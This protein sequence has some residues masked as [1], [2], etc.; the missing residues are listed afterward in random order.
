MKRIFY[1]VDFGKF[2]EATSRADLQHALRKYVN[3]D[4]AAEA[5]AN[6]VWS[7]SEPFSA[8][9]FDKRTGRIQKHPRTN[10]VAVSLAE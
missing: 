6:V 9:W 4:D 10:C 5:V 2:I 3:N 7:L 1:V 8:R